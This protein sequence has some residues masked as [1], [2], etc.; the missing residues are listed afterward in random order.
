MT[1]AAVLLEVAPSIALRAPASIKAE[2]ATIIVFFTFQR[3]LNVG[4]PALTRL[5]LYHLSG[6]CRVLARAYM[7][8]DYP[9]SQ[10]HYRNRIENSQ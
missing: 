5:C 6:S 3:L 2:R 8:P 9:G 10:S 4:V 7:R 1:M